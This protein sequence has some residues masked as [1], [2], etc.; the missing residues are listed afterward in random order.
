MVADLRPGVW[1]SRPAHLVVDSG[2]LYFA[3]N[4]GRHGIDLWRSYATAAG[5]RLGSDIRPGPHGSLPSF[6][7]AFNGRVY[8]AATDETHGTELWATDSTEQGAVLVADVLPGVLGASPAHL[9]RLGG[10]LWFSAEDGPAT[11]RAW[12]TDG[13]AQGLRREWHPAP[14]GGTAARYTTWGEA[15]AYVA[16][17]G[18][19]NDR[20]WRRS[21]DGQVSLVGAALQHR[22]R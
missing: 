7:T 9:T 17:D 11:T 18:H 22:L 14:P 12:S 2:V 4:D 5:T 20:L 21:A 3:A 19:G 1:G 15:T 10:R 6:L 8:F 16:G 13:T